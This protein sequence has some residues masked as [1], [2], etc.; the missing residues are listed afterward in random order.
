MTFRAALMLASAAA[1]GAH[2]ADSALVFAQSAQE[3]AALDA[4]TDSRSAYVGEAR[5]AEGRAQLAKGDTAGARANITRGLEGVRRGGGA[6]HPLVRE[7][8]VLTS[9]LRG[10]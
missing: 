4:L 8:Q 6:E 7:A 1:L 3:I 5:I 10:G 9:A 2:H